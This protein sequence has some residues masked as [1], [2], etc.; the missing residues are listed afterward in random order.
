MLYPAEHFQMC[1]LDGPLFETFISPRTPLL[2]MEHLRHL[3][4]PISR[5]ISYERT[6]DEFLLQLTMNDA[7]RQLRCRNEMVILLDRQ[8]ALLCQEGQWSLLFTPDR[9]EKH[10]VLSGEDLYPI[11]AQM[12]QSC[13]LGQVCQ[14]QI[15]RRSA[16]ALATGRAPFCILDEFCQRQEGGFLKVARDVVIEGPERLLAHVPVCR[17]GALSTVDLGEIESYHAVKALLDEYI[18]RYDHRQELGEVRPVSLAVFGP[19]G[20]GKSFGVRQIAISRGRFNIS[21]LNVSQYGT[22]AELFAGLHLALDYEDGRIPLVFFDEFD[23]ELN[24]LPRGWL[25]YFLA[26]MQDGEYTCQGQ[27]LPIPG[28]VFVF[29]GATASTFAEFLPGDDPEHVQQFQQIKGPDFVSRLKGILNIKGP[30]RTD[31]TDKKHIIRRAMLLRG[32]IIQNARGCYDPATGR[33]EISQSLLHALLRVSEF[34]HGARSIEFVLGMSRLAEARRYTSSCLPLA[35]QLDIHLDVADFMRKLSFE[36]VMGSM[37]EQYA[38]TAHARYQQLRLQEA[39][40]HHATP[41]DLEQLRRS[42]PEMADW[43]ELDE[44]YKEGHRSQ[45]RY[46]GEHLAA[47]GTG[48]CLRPVLPEAEDAITEL[49]GPALEQLC[50]MEHRRWMRDK[51]KDGWILGPLDKELRH[52][53]DLLPYEELDGSVQ[54]FI[55][56]NVR[57]IPGYLREIGYELSR[58]AF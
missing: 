6:V 3:D 22:V 19:P 54:D 14:V 9:S 20:S 23:S 43:E 24:G 44:F 33:I 45:I 40:A 52:H 5:E 18:Y 10:T 26:P 46:L 30:N 57:S 1:P 41:Q 50:Q 16:K 17:Y 38:R 56:T 32:Q 15:P 35:Q 28:A 51:L 34:R 25:K 37:V 4:F 27:T 13:A 39:M 42:D 31:M 48:L 58:T 12:I 11:Y 7:L 21:S 29:A 36:Q 55:R 53:P 8:G 47:F 49:Y 2:L